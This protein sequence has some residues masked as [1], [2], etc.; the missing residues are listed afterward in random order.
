MTTATKDQ[1]VQS[2][3]N[4]ANPN[5]IADALQKVE[6]GNVI[7]PVKVTF[8]GLA[9]SAT[10]DITTA[11]AKAAATV[12]GLTLALGENLP[13]MLVVRTLRVTAGAAAAAPRVTTDA[14]GTP[15]ATYAT[16]SDDGT[17]LVFEDTVTAC[18]LEYLPRS[19]TPLS[20]TLNT[21]A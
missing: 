4:D 20:T 19:A 16:I 17:T 21:F 13:A 5:E 18:V 1:T 11:A 9:A 15:S 14:A 12:T 3:L 2:C 10:L 6:L 8:A 7:S